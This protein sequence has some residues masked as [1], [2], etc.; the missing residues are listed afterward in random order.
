V[1]SHLNYWSRV[2]TTYKK[3][4]DLISLIH[5]PMVSIKV[6]TAVKHSVIHS[7]IHSFIHSFIDP[8]IHSFIQTHRYHRQL[9]LSLPARSSPVHPSNPS[10]SDNCCIFN[11]IRVLYYPG[12]QCHHTTLVFNVTRHL[13]HLIG[14]DLRL[15]IIESLDICGTV[16]LLNIN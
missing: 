15:A 10:Y 13:P 12:I 3:K 16:M 2:A 4:R 11:V 1:F 5:A 9:L 7:L 14:G 8:F 6:K